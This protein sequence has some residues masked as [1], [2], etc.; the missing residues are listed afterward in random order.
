MK[1]YTKTNNSNFYAKI[2]L[3]K[4]SFKEYFFYF[5]RSLNKKIIQKK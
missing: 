4:I 3:F 1:I 2:K 5:F